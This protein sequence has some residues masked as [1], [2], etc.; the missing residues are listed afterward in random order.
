MVQYIDI[1]FFNFEMRSDNDP[2]QL[3]DAIDVFWF[4]Q[5]LCNVKGDNYIVKPFRRRWSHKKTP[6]IVLL[7]PFYCH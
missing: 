1:F 3:L 7:S 5:I 2:C 4:N 6:Y